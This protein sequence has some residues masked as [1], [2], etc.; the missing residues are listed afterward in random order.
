MRDC[1]PFGHFV[2]LPLVWTGFELCATQGTLLTFVL[3][4]IGLLSSGFHA[5]RFQELVS[6][7]CLSGHLVE[8]L[9]RDIA[10]GGSLLRHHLRQPALMQL[11]LRH[12]GSK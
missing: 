2:K 9:G 11:L 12:P 7:S 5:L 8:L 4:V 10:H 3:G 6:D 1:S